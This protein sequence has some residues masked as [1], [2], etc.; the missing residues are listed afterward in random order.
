M[1]GVS[2]FL[3]YNSHLY[4]FRHVSCNLIQETQVWGMARELDKIAQ[5]VFNNNSEK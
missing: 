1:W 4:N 2:C 5:F 3:H